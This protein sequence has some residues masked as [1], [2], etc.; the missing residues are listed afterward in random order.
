M[1]TT[2]TNH[3]AEQAYHAAQAQITQA[4]D[5]IETLMAQ[6]KARAAKEGMHWGHVGD[7]TEVLAQLQR[8]TNPDA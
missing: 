8:I 4:L 5:A 6:H 3:K 2:V 7:L 1:A